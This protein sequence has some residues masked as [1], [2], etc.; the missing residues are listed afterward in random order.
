MADLFEIE[1]VTNFCNKYTSSEI[2]WNDLAFIG[3]SI[4]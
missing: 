4:R 3:N 2:Y 1:S